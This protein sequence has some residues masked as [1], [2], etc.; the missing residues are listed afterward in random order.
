M[1]G[2]KR[3]SG[4][5][6]ARPG[7][8]KRKRGKMTSRDLK[9]LKEYGS[10]NTNFDANYGDLHQAIE[11]VINKKKYQFEMR[12]DAEGNELQ[13]VDDLEA[14]ESTKALA[15]SDSGSDSSDAE[16]TLVS[17]RKRAHTTP[18]QPL[19][20]LKAGRR[21]TDGSDSEDALDLDPA[22][23]S[24]KGPLFIPAKSVLRRKKVAEPTN[25]KDD[26]DVPT[27]SAFRELVGML[28]HDDRIL[29]HADV[30]S[31]DSNASSDER[32]DTTDAVGTVVYSSD[33]DQMMA[34]DEKYDDDVYE[35]VED[36]EML[37]ARLERDLMDS[38]GQLSSKSLDGP[39]GDDSDSDIEPNQR[40]RCTLQVDRV[41]DPREAHFGDGAT[42]S[43]A[44]RVAKVEA[45]QYQMHRL[46]NNILHSVTTYATDSSRTRQLLATLAEPIK[47][48][49]D[50][51][52][53][54]ST[55]QQ[56]GKLPRLKSKQA[57]HELEVQL[58]RL[59]SGYQDLLYCNRT[60][61][62]AP[63]VRR[64]YVMHV[65]NHVFKDQDNIR[66][67]TRAQQDAARQKQEPEEMRDQGFTRPKA[68]IL[69]PFRSAAYKIIQLI[70]HL[71]NKGEVHN[72]REVVGNFTVPPE[73]DVA[74]PSKPKD[75]NQIF[76]GNMDDYFRMGIKFTA[77]RVEFFSSFYDSD[78]LIASPLGLSTAL[79]DREFTNRDDVHL[80]PTDF[81]SSIEIVVVDQCNIIQMQNWD[82]VNQVFQC[83]NQI[84][85]DTHGC[86]FARVKRWLLDG[87]AQYLRQTLVF[88]DFLT[89]EL[90]AMF[91]TT[92]R[93]V[94][95]K[96]RVR[97][98][99]PAGT[100]AD[101]IPKVPQVFT[102]IDCSQAA[103]APDARFK[104]F[105][106]VFLPS[107][108][109]S[110]LFKSNNILIFIP[111]YFDF[112]RIRNYFKENRLSFTFLNEYC[113]YSRARK[114]R[115]RFY[116]GYKPY[117]L[118]TERY[119][120]YQRP[121][122]QPVKHVIFYELPTHPHFYAEI[123]NLMAK[124]SLSRQ[125][126]ESATVDDPEALA[127]RQTAQALAEA[128]GGDWT[129]SILFTKYDQLK[130]ERVVGT[131]NAKALVSGG[132]LVY[133]FT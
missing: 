80:S 111:S 112:V 97:Q 49:V 37:D 75:Y 88:S 38:T 95:G 86:D 91:N 115:R 45:R 18:E 21:T 4:L 126:A 34:D 36:A 59:M 131:T 13:T 120:F 110:E 116:N 20:H 81:L 133:T 82:H 15:S 127:S 70:L 16:D 52:L 3:V 113:S 23:L 72:K 123:V 29:D 40:S 44:D 125:V 62:N 43:L 11:G 22:Q 109:T 79:K 77:R 14:A 58:L 96:V 60:H 64:S 85:T 68:L 124:T 122:V 51:H 105:T 132:K 114:A 129:C 107:V 104:Y 90:N 65:L 33:E 67:N 30:F 31:S 102:R 119:H 99:W 84:P 130:L 53:H 48:A 24:Q 94:A 57:N 103:M 74:N 63:S 17:Q 54:P 9:M 101:V 5:A 50:L 2:K 1:R 98:D 106:E 8:T 128:T 100:I 108:Q 118:Y 89:P 73:D 32:D 27:V 26:T 42:D 61:I 10:L 25:G 87:Q 46:R 76:R 19:V 12:L 56:W 35:L 117:L 93:N 6:S 41:A 121:Q 71:A 83:L 28:R 78:V 66:R 7:P 69:V 47:N 39:S 55:W 92:M